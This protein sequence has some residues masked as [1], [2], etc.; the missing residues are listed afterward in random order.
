MLGSARSPGVTS[1]TRR[2]AATSTSARRTSPST[3]FAPQVNTEY[4]V[5]Y[6]LVDKSWVDL[7]LGV[8]PLFMVPPSCPAARS[9]GFCQISHSERHNLAEDGRLVMQMEHPVHKHD[10]DLEFYT[11]GKKLGYLRERSKAFWWA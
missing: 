7:D 2:A 3:R 8:P 5:S 10:L 1:P 6:L 4:R 9:S 11:K